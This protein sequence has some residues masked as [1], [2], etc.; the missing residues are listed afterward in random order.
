MNQKYPNRS[1]DKHLNKANMMKATNSKLTRGHLKNGDFR[2][3]LTHL[4]A[5][6]SAKFWRN[7]RKAKQS[8]TKIARE[9]Q[10]LMMTAIFD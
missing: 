7:Q 3:M 1:S 9:L 6:N 8:L 10:D 2:L 5:K 4:V